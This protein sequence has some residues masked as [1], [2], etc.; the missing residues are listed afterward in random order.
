MLYMAWERGGGGGGGS[1]LYLVDNEIRLLALI[2][3]YMSEG[4]V[5]DALN[6]RVSLTFPI[7]GSC[8]SKSEVLRSGASE[9]DAMR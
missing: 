1:Y 3:D 6:T 5:T 7:A 8:S 4:V 2:T 9:R